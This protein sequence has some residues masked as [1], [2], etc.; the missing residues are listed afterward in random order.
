MTLRRARFL[1][2]LVAALTVLAS[3]LPSATPRPEPGG[4]FFTPQTFVGDAGNGY[5]VY[6]LSYFNL[7]TYSGTIPT[8]LYKF[9]FGF[10]YFLGPVSGDLSSDEAY[11]YDYTAQ[12]YLYTTASLYPY[13][14]SFNRRTFLYY[15]EDSNPREFYDFNAQGFINY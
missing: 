14:Y 2:P 6:Y 9:N 11:F 4:N 3:P 15:F 10:L 8:N 7:Y 1:L 13:F 5:S 12:D